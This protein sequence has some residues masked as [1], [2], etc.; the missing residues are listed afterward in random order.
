MKRAIKK[1]RIDTNI[2][3]DEGI[4]NRLEGEKIINPADVRESQL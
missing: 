3:E 1:I 4:N 2:D